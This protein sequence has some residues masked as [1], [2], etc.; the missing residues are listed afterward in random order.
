MDDLWKLLADAA[1]TVISVLAQFVDGMLHFVEDV[2]GDFKDL[3]TQPLEIPFFST[4]YE[5]VT[6]LLGD[7]EEFTVINGV[8]FLISIPLVTMMRVG[9]YGIPPEHNTGMD[10]PS[11][12]KK[13]HDQVHAALN[14]SRAKSLKS[15]KAMKHIQPL[16]AADDKPSFEPPIGLQVYS[17]VAGAINAVCAIIGNALEWTFLT[18]GGIPYGLRGGLAALRLIFS[19][20]M[21]KRNV[22]AQ[23]YEIRWVAWVIGNAW[24][25]FTTFLKAVPPPFFKNG[26]GLGVN[27]VMEILAAVCDSRDN[28]TGMTWA[29]DMVSNA[30]GAFATLGKLLE[31]DVKNKEVGTPMKYAA[32]FVAIGG[33]ITSFVNAGG[34]IVDA[35]EGHDVWTGIL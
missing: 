18:A 12:P 11:F 1:D 2:L 27:V 29:G 7:G 6:E 19:A 15:S 23:A 28:V 33:N 13:L 14:P 34:A 8:S 16:A 25:C 9:G 5:F 10:D 21:P 22:D 17:G 35:A 24:R 20:P 26:G 31:E 3:L 32:A 30:G 4:L